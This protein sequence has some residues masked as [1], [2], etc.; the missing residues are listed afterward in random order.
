M[1][2]ALGSEKY[3]VGDV[4]TYSYLL[5]WRDDASRRLLDEQLAQLNAQRTSART[6]L[7]IHGHTHVPYLAVQRRGGTSHELGPIRYGE[8]RAL[9]EF[10]AVLINSGS[11]GQPRNSDPR[12]HAAYGILDTANCAFM[13]RRVFYD[14]ERTRLKMAELNY[15]RDPIRLSSRAITQP[16]RCATAMPCGWSGNEPIAPNR[17][18]GNQSCEWIGLIFMTIRPA[19]ICTRRTTPKPRWQWVTVLLLLSLLG[20]RTPVHGQEGSPLSAPKPLDV[21]LLID[22]SP[23]TGDT[24]PKGWR[25]SASRFLLDYLQ[26]TS[27]VLRVNY[28]AGVAN[29]GGRIGATTPLRL[30]EGGIVQG[31]IVSETISYTDFRPPLDWALREFRARS[32]GVGNAMAVILFT[33][34]NPQLTQQPLTVAPEGA[35]FYGTALSGRC[36]R[37]G[38]FPAWSRKCRMPA[39]PC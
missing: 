15:D 7:L 13:F 5:P 37:T 27:Q 2:A 22:S 35:L 14:S 28:R 8:W 11:V 1:H 31:T 9:A 32:F 20:A 39:S 6:A 24:D 23:S 12:V 16:A 25:I 19:G 30:L 18:V 38:V 36:Q 3:N 21:I 34:G 26:A 17:G 10:Q 29:F 4:P 33:D